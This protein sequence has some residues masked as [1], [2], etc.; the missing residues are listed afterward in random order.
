MFSHDP[1]VRTNTDS[2]TSIASAYHTPPP[3][4]NGHFTVHSTSILI[5]YKK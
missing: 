3:P 4:V 2:V 5:G 1:E